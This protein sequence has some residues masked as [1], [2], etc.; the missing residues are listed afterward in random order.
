MAL[1]LD[2]NGTS[3]RDET[4]LDLAPLDSSLNQKSAT[5]SPTPEIAT[6]ASPPAVNGTSNNNNNNNN[7]TTL[8]ATVQD[9]TSLDA[10]P[11]AE[12][13]SAHEVDLSF[14]DLPE[15]KSMTDL[16]DLPN[17]ADA[18]LANLAIATP[19]LS[20]SMNSAI[21]AAVEDHVGASAV[22]PVIDAQQSDLRDTEPSSAS[23]PVL[24]PDT[25]AIQ[26]KLEDN[27]DGDLAI[28]AAEDPEPASDLPAPVTDASDTKM[29]APQ[30]TV[31]QGQSESAIDDTEMVDAPPRSPTQPPKISREREEDD[32]DDLD[33]ERAAKRTKTED[34]TS[35]APSGSPMAAVNGHSSTGGTE[36]SDA[37]TP[38]QA[39]ELIK[40]IKNAARTQ[41]GK[42]FRAPV[43][44]LWPQFA[45][46]YALLVPNQIDL[47]TMEK[48][49]R[50]GAYPTLES[51]QSDVRLLYNNAVLFNGVDHMIS[52]AA[53]DVK[54]SILSKTT[55]IPPEV[56]QAPKPAKKATI[57][58]STPTADSG[59]RTTPTARRG[60]RAGVSGSGIKQETFAL[61]PSGVPLIR[62]DSTKLDGGRPKREIHPPKNK[63]L[64]YNSVRPKN[65]KNA[66]ELR[67]C[68]IVLNEMKKPKY[69]PISSA[70]MTPVDP[71][72]LGVP[73]YFSVIKNPMDF[74][75]ISDKLAS[76]HY[77]KA[78]DFEHDVRLVFSNCYKFNPPGNAVHTWGKEFEAVF[79]SQ[80]D[81]KQQ[82]IGDHTPAAASPS[83]S[84]DSDEDESEDEVQPPQAAAPAATSAFAERLIAE[85]ATLIQLMSQKSANKA[86]VSM[87]Q[88]I[89]QMLQGKVDEEKAQST[90][91]KKPAKKSKTA[92]AKPT[93]KAGQVKKDKSSGTSGGRKPSRPRYMGTVEK[94]IVSAGIGLLPDATQD[95]VME[96]IRGD[97]PD[98]EADADGALE[99]DIEMLTDP[100]LWEIYSMIEK[101]LPE[102]V[103]NIK[104][105][106]EAERARNRTPAQ[107]K[108][109]KKNKPM[110]KTEQE[111]KIE[112]LRNTMQE[113]ERHGSG[114]QEPV[115]PTVEQGDETSGDETSDS[116]E[117]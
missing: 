15:T 26:P 19:D 14:S 114:S 65:K 66:T 60:S 93:K 47:G 81:K 8:S 38:Y 22:L 20:S 43:D 61:D 91:P 2:I 116:E 40:I 90:A 88:A 106:K 42:N 92:V 5:N 49:V 84:G 25:D 103:R 58:R 96:I 115:M 11:A 74:G 68:E 24:A 23:A 54:D 112:Q 36:T 99:L 1:D 51:F 41:G 3:N 27:H 72:A 69:A 117:E 37:I 6:A 17:V 64:P 7:P 31:V 28:R 100:S 30:D 21:D 77:Q 16:P 32:E 59:P 9:P 52:K 13:P 44:T 70:F 63:D 86:E 50:D 46:Q 34:R 82:W 35:E 75:T 76:G 107:P 53:R 98:A 102:T 109:K 105:Q 95:R 33:A 62:R 108:Q 101:H 80:W 83:V 45:E 48:K 87:Q 57:K 104:A 4:N 78:K 56:V 89:V 113:F 12:L 110:S 71:V 39:K 55:S 10:T 79:D 94:E 97:A 85:Q 18:N 111:R 67:F 29:S 73:T